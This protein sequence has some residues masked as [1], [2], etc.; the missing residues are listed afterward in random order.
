MRDRV[1]SLGKYL[2]E[3][4]N[5]EMLRLRATRSERKG[6]TIA[7]RQTPAVLRPAAAAAIMA[8]KIRQV[9]DVL[10]VEAVVL[11]R[12]GQVPVSGFCVAIPGKSGSPPSKSRGLEK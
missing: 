11:L 6:P 9:R 5:A 4:D 10:E 7:G 12:M 8:P 2:Q 3:L 1:G